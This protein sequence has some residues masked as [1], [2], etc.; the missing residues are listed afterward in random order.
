MAVGS[1]PSERAMPSVSGSDRLNVAVPSIFWAAALNDAM[2]S[3]ERLEWVCPPVEGRYGCEW[4]IR[5]PS[6]RVWVCINTVFANTKFMNTHISIAAVI[7]SRY[8]FTP[9]SYI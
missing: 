1:N 9:Q 2:L 4:E 7:C 3:R 5:E 8:L 6:A